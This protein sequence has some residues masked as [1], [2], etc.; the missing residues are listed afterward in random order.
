[1][2]KKNYGL[3]LCGG[4]GKG[5]YQIG[6][7]KALHALGL[8]SCIRG[9]A[10]ASAGALNA[11]LFLN[12]SYETAEEV[13][14]KIRP[15]QFLDIEPEGYCSREGILKLMDKNIDLNRVSLS[16]VPA[17]IS[18]TLAAPGTYENAGRLNTAMASL[19]QDP[20][21]RVGDYLLVNGRKPEEIKKLLLASTAIPFIYDPVEIDGQLYRDGGLFDNVP[22]RPL[23]EIGLKDLIIVKCSANQQCNPY[24]LSQADSVL[25]IVPSADIG[26]LLT[27]TLDFDGRNAMYRLQV[28]YFD[29]IRSTEYFDRR[30]LGLPPSEAEKQQRIAQD[31]E[32][33]VSNS[34]MAQHLES[35]DRNRSKLDE[36]MKKYGL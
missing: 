6:V 7:F 33:A 17:Y 18:V 20:E 9:I 15:I 5:A 27:G 22:I 11:V 4:G 31:L 36:I 12:G 23:L 21:D 2:E 28:G 1:M 10:G 16:P 32:R 35:I 8:D 29:T 26:S 34:K 19:N 24:L 25:E 14:T 13:W 30:A 3:V